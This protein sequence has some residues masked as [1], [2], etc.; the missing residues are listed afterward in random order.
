LIGVA[1]LSVVLRASFTGSFEHGGS[2][3]FGVIETSEKDE[4]SFEKAFCAI[5]P[6]LL[7]F[8]CGLENDLAC[9]YRVLGK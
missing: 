5:A 8:A 6:H 7:R 1:A 3:C 2:V 9:R 4:G